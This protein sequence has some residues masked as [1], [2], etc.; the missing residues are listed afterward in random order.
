MNSIKEKGGRMDVN[1]LL[2]NYKVKLIRLIDGDTMVVDIDQGFDVWMKNQKLRLSG[3][4]AWEIRKRKNVTAAEIKKGKKALEWLKNKFVTEIGLE[5]YISSEA[6]NYRGSFG[7]ILATIYYLSK[8]KLIN[9][10]EEMVKLG[11]AR[12]VKY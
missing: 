11:H 6:V 8:G 4:N 7:R 12:K 3:I 2:Y 10:N 9:L 1:E 5:F